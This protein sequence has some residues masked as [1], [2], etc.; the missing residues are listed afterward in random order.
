MLA[1]LPVF[2]FRFIPFNCNS[3]CSLFF[4]VVFVSPPCTICI[5]LSGPL[6]D[7]LQDAMIY[8]A[9]VKGHFGYDQ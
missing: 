8:S 5:I 3:S 1:V 6:P 4:L 2:R 9:E 7:V